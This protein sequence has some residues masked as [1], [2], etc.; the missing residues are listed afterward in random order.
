MK[1]N[2]SPVYRNRDTNYIKTSLTLKLGTKDRLQNLAHKG[3]SFDDVINRLIRTNEIMEERIKEYEALLEK[4]NLLRTNRLEISRSERGI[5]SV[6]LS[7]G[8][9]VQFS[10]NKPTNVLDDEYSMDISIDEMI[11]NKGPQFSVEDL[12]KDVKK[13]SQI[14]FRCVEQVIVRQFDRSFAIPLNKNV[15]D[16]SYW[17]KVWDR[18][19]LSGRSYMSDILKYLDEFMGG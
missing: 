8:S 18:V 6:R 11:G 12:K 19:G 14:Y 2:S 13:H 15:I 17:Q 7:D 5:G 1:K 10:Y 3:E 9:V 16:P 4:E